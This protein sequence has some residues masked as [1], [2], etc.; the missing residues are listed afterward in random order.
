MELPESTGNFAVRQSRLLHVESVYGLV[1]DTLIS[2]QL[3]AERLVPSVCMGSVSQLTSPC[4]F[5]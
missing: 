4:A 2:L 3:L 1:S 5:C